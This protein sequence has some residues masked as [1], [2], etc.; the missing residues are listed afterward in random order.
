MSPTTALAVPSAGRQRAVQAAVCTATVLV[1]GFVA[2][3]NLAVPMLARSGL[4]PGPA[5]LLW[6]VDAYVVFFACLVIPAGA[7]GD[8]FGRKGALMAGL[9]VFAAGAALSAVAPDAAVLL[10]GRGI[11]GVGAALVLPNGLAVLVHATEPERRRRALT[12]WAAMSGIGGVIGNVG[13]GAILSAGSWHL[14]FALVAPAAVLLLGWIA[15]VAPR[16]SRTARP[17][18]VWGAL[19]LT[20]A[21]VALVLGIIDGPERGWGSPFVCAAFVLAAALWAAWVIVGLRTRDPLLDPRLFKLPALTA[22]CVGM[23]VA[24]F[25]NFGLFYVNASLLQYVHGFSVFVAGLGI[26]PMIV[27]LLIL[28]RFVPRLVNRF[29]IPRVLAP[30]FVVFSAGLFGLSLVTDGS[31]VA[32]AVCLFVIGVGMAP[33]LPALTVE[34]TGALPQH[35]AGVGGGLQSAT[36]ELGSALGVAVVGTIVTQTFDVPGAGGTAHTVSAALAAD[37][38]HHAAVIDAYAHATSLALRITSGIVL[39]AGA[40]AVILTLRA[41]RRARQNQTDPSSTSTGITPQEA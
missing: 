12:T 30:A 9:A 31:Y 5:Q 14:L 24:F 35:Q 36:R 41:A 26:L 28:P 21:S 33:A 6:I 27:P 17:I 32:Y 16:S 20:A 40:V 19:L 1:V 29:G 34:I 2:S 23:L 15:A 22:G 10:V 13:G 11:T 25:G 39:L 4:H 38:A 37:P 7:I 8:R 18:D 3:I